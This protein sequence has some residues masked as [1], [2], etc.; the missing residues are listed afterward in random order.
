VGVRFKKIAGMG[1]VSMALAGAWTVLAEPATFTRLD[2]VV[3]NPSLYSGY[4]YANGVS[5]DGAVVVGRSYAYFSG[6]FVPVY[7]VGNTAIEIPTFPGNFAYDGSAAAVSGDGRYVAGSWT[8]GNSP[9]NLEAFRYDTLTGVIQPLGD[10]PGNEQFM[11]S[12]A[13]I[14]RAGRRIAGRSASTGLPNGEPALW[15][16]PS[17]SMQPIIRRGLGIP[18]NTYSSSEGRSS[19][20]S[21]SGRWVFGTFSPGGV[22]SQDVFAWTDSVQGEG[23]ST[24]VPSP[25]Y[26][27]RA[28]G[29]N[30][31]GGIVACSLQQGGYVSTPAIWHNPAM[32]GTGFELLPVLPD[33]NSADANAASDDGSVVVGRGFN[34]E[35]WG[36]YDERAVMWREGVGI[37]AI[38]DLLRDF[39]LADLGGVTLQAATGVS[40]DGQTIV[41]IGYRADFQPTA[42][43]A[44]IPNCPADFNG[45]GGVDGQD[46]EAFHSAWETSVP[47]ADVNFDGG[48]DGGDVEV[49]F[50]AWEAG[51]CS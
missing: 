46:V 47:Y 40:A 2:N 20:I 15:E 24:L 32:G 9:Y 13:A 21:G 6:A 31:D 11:S 26:V 37:V 39:Y 41:G 50:T 23:G 19:S 48:V 28:N 22:N 4:T 51:G 42:W 1:L 49:F 30:H 43:K 33:Q 5:A 36:I 17:N 25:W 45:D 34:A 35:F 8:W 29:T 10:L 14:D 27:N 12:A 16:I 44:F 38:Q 3:S 7:W 18:G